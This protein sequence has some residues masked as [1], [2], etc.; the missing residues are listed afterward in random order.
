[1]RARPLNVGAAHEH[2]PTLQNANELQQAYDHF[3]AALFAGE[4]PVCLITLQRQANCHGYFSPTRFAHRGGGYTDEIAMNPE[5]FANF[6][7]I[8]TLQTLVHEMAHLWQFHFGQP[9]RR[10]Y[11]NREWATRME[12]IGLMP[13]STGKPGGAKTGERMADYPIAGGPFV[14]A[15]KELFTRDFRIS[16]YDRFPSHRGAPIAANEELE[17]ELGVSLTA[18]MPAVSEHLNGGGV[19]MLRPRRNTRSKY[20]CPDCGVQVWG[21][22]GLNLSCGDCGDPFHEVMPAEG[23]PASESGR[24]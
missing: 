14:A 16:W 10:A 19:Q 5:Y 2:A 20:A 17:R 3:N 11:H 4:L 15:C 22:P 21:K 8:E 24:D 23:A 6:P 13:S 1:M 18:E 9:G 7:M 12:A